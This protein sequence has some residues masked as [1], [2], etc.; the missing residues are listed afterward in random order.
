MD[1]TV[2]GV[3]KSRTQLSDFHITSLTTPQTTMCPYP[4]N[5]QAP[6][7]GEGGPEIYSHLLAW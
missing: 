4:I 5:I 6:R 1:Y 7:F 2:H 3:A